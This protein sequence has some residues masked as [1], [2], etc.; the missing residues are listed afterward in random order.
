MCL[1]VSLSLKKQGIPLQH[2]VG[3]MDNRVYSKKQVNAV[4]HLGFFIDFGK[5]IAMCHIQIGQDHV[6]PSVQI[7]FGQSKC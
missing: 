3:L 2:K 6:Q 1:I 4:S 5:K 7:G